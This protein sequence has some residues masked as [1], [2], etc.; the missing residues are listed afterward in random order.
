MPQVSVGS[1]LRV[2]SM[3]FVR[4]AVITTILFTSGCSLP[5][6]ILQ[7]H[8]QGLGRFEFREAADGLEGIVIGAPHGRTD[9]L[10]D[11]L[12]KSISDRTGAG[13]VI[14]YGF[15]S[16]RLSVTQPVAGFYPHLASL[17][18]LQRGS[19]FRD[20]KRILRETAKGDLALYV[21]IHRSSESEVSDRIEVATSGLTFEEAGALK[22]AYMQIRDQLSSKQEVP[23][24]RMSI[25]PLD[26]IS[27]HAPGVKHHGILLF[28]EKG[29][30][31]RVPQMLSGE[32]AEELY[33]EILSRWAVRAIEILRENSLRLP[34]IKVQRMDLGRLEMVE[35]R[36]R[37]PGVVIAAP[38][39]SYD[40]YTAEVV[41]RVSHRARLAAIIAKGFTPT[42]AEGWRINVNRPTEKTPY[43]E[44][45]EPHSRRAARVYH[46]FKEIVFEACNR[47]LRLYIDI[48][49]YS[50]DTKI[51]IATV[52]IP[53]AQARI[54]KMLYYEIRDRI[55]AKEPNIP[56]VDLVIEP[57]DVVEIGAW[58][59]KLEGILSLA[60][61]S[62]HIEIPGHIAF[63]TPE[64]RAIYTQLLAA[65]FQ[66]VAPFLLSRAEHGRS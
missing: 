11:S 43:S 6:P 53:V 49:Q 50:T 66:E 27:W 28:A 20:Y 1:I 12:A 37:L 40:E 58:A 7:E 15:K 61:K 3:T 36:N 48:H 2:R 23:M 62:L 59:A 39:G 56:A 51:Q 38:H 45:F 29:L 4:L 21:G 64:A 55:L 57:L 30:N 60:K 46:A 47:D 5:R 33:A 10:S 17:N 22:D 26:R 25:E 24:L 14:A 31:L 52:G 35:P 65:L 8:V 54:V 63:A 32:L 42:E 19:V 9:R 16:K 13:L 18:P 34:Q 44:G 41:K